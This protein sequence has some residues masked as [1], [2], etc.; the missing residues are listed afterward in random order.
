VLRFVTGVHLQLLLRHLCAAGVQHSMPDFAY[1]DNSERPP[2]AF[3]SSHA[4]LYAAGTMAAIPSSPVLCA[5]DIV[6]K[7][8]LTAVSAASWDR[9]FL[10]HSQCQYGWLMGVPRGGQPHFQERA[11]QHQ[12]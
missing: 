8:S 1:D 6:D 9:S 7:P 5:R 4:V 11:V 3:C 10:K 12:L 2:H